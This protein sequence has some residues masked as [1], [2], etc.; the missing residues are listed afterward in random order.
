MDSSNATTPE[1]PSGLSQ[2]FTRWDG[3]DNADCT[4]NAKVLAAA[5]R[6]STERAYQIMRNGWETHEK[7]R[8]LME[9]LPKP[10]QHDLLLDYVSG[11]SFTIAPREESTTELPARLTARLVKLVAAFNHDLLIA[12]ADGKIDDAENDMLEPLLCEQERMI[13]QIRAAKNSRRTHN[14]RL[15]SVV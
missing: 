8:T 12:M 6:F 2:I 10:V 1:L 5:G 15:A 9:R 14:M 11:T 7:S 3:V 4:F 13:A